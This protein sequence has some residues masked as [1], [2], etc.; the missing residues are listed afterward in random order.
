MF[1]EKHGGHA[2]ERFTKYLSRRTVC[3]MGQAAALTCGKSKACTTVLTHIIE[4]FG[5]FQPDRP[6]LKGVV[7]FP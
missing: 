4:G 5:N 7:I 3:T 1:E 6:R 2:Q